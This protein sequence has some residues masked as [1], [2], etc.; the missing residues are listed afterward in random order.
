MRRSN[1][2]LRSNH[3]PLPNEKKDN[4]FGFDYTPVPPS[5]FAEALQWSY[6]EL[7]TNGGRVMCQAGDFDP[8]PRAAKACFCEQRMPDTLKRVGAENSTISCNGAVFF[9]TVKEGVKGTK[10]AFNSLLE[11]KYL[12]KNFTTGGSTEMT[13]N[14]NAFGK[15]EFLPDKEKECFCDSSVYYS[16]AR[17]QIDMDRFKAQDTLASLETQLKSQ[18]EMQEK[19]IKERDEAA[20]K[21]KQYEVDR[22]KLRA[23][24]QKKYEK[25]QK[26]DYEKEEK[27]IQ[28]L[29]TE[30]NK[31]ISDKI[32]AL[33][34]SYTEL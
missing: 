25:E 8:A 22:E 33:Q 7:K 32:A 2:A 12:V 19:V 21:A 5:S 4:P 31:K 9:G 6:A 3:D 29:I 16:A 34:K 26:D 24:F 30:N 23:D 20:K 27:K 13:C 28:K 14:S 1:G 15:S 11:T 17:V 10:A 18:K